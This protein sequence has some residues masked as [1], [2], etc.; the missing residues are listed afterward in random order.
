MRLK[1]YEFDGNDII[2]LLG[3]AVLS[4]L[5]GP[6]A[7]NPDIDKCHALDFVLEEL[8]SVHLS[9]QENL[10]VGLTY[11]PHLHACSASCQQWDSTSMNA[12]A[13]TGVGA[14]RQAPPNKKLAEDNI[15]KLL[16]ARKPRRLRKVAT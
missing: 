14:A 12:T 11:M 3:G 15:D 7:W 10:R 5:R 1:V 13:G 6:S 4:L 9:L 8:I 16:P 2:D